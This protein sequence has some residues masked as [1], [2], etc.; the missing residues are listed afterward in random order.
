[1]TK[2]RTNQ[3]EEQPARPLD[4]EFDP[5]E[6]S[7]TSPVTASEI[8]HAALANNRTLDNLL[9]SFDGG[10]ASPADATSRVSASTVKDTLM[11]RT[12]LW[13]R[14]KPIAQSQEHLRADTQTTTNP[15]DASSAS[16]ERQEQKVASSAHGPSTVLRANT[17]SVLRHRS[18]APS[19]ST[20]SSLS[21]LSPASST[22]FGNP[23]RIPVAPNESQI[24]LP[25]LSAARCTVCERGHSDCEQSPTCNIRSKS[26]EPESPYRTIPQSRRSGIP[27][28]SGRILNARH[29]K[30]PH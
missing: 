15:G 26:A 24:E 6:S 30:S 10:E 1:M 23:T 29:R 9:D 22:T 18:P 3:E 16:G 25:N 8:Y 12:Q 2:I 20:T 21:S 28:R 7:V 13:M 5:G 11:H 17:Q 4:E 19:M 14:T 27:R